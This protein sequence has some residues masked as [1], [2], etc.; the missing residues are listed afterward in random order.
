MHDEQEIIIKDESSNPAPLG[1]LGFGLT[2][3]LLN[4]H[5]AGLYEMNAMILMMGV[6][7]GGLAQIVAGGMEWHK[8]NTFGTTAFLSYG[9]FWLSLV[10]IVVL[11]MF[12][13][14]LV[15]AGVSMGWYLTM[16]GILTVAFFIGT[17]R[18]TKALQFVFGTLS[19]LFFLLAAGYFTGN[20]MFIT[21]AGF[22]GV[23]CGLSA[24]YVAVA[25]VLN[26]VYKKPVLPL[27]PVGK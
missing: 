5:N 11:P 27:G 14:S 10:G 8:G 25:Q 1:L 22:E 24:I 18:L 16:W 7:Y 4:L 20:S 3:V 9:F 26:D 21:I 23:L 12:I 6:F 17:F 2:T 15:V 19:L 13:P